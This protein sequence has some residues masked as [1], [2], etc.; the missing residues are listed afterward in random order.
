MN[1]KKATGPEIYTT[2]RPG[3]SSLPERRAG[4]RRARQV[5][6]V[7]SLSDVEVAGLVRRV[8]SVGDAVCFSL[9]SDSGCFSTTI[10]AGGKRHK[11]Y[12]ATEEEVYTV[13]HDLL[14]ELYP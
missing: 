11:V 9:T 2:Q 12:G 10:L 4:T 7:D 14:E 8:V 13:W 1:G 5:F 3:P 6:E